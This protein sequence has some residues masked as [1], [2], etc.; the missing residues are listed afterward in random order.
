MSGRGHRRSREA[1]V[2]ELAAVPVFAALDDAEMHELAASAT[3][4]REP[5]G[6]VFSREGERGDELV[7]VLEGQLEVRHDDTAL[8]TL[9]PGDIMGEMALVTDATRRNATVVAVT[10][11]VVAYLSRHHVD[12]LMARHDAFAAAVRATVAARTPSPAGEHAA[13]G[14]GQAGDPAVSHPE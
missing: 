14:P 8:A 2:R 9:G 11:V 12:L 13:S 7:V 10:P 3:R 5:R 1:F 4:A 6:M